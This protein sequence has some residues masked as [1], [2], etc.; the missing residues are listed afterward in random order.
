MTEYTIKLTIQPESYDYNDEEIVYRILFDKQLISERS[1]PK[2]TNNQK[3]LDCFT[4]NVEQTNNLRILDLE[5]VK[6]KRCILF[7]ANINGT[8]YKIPEISQT[9][10]IN[11]KDMLLNIRQVQINTF[12]ELA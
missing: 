10:Q 12:E 1:L 4:I 2:L 3:L 8:S 7:D 9:I 5:N 6:D 11:L